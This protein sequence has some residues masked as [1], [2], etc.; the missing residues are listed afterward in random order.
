MIEPKHI[1]VFQIAMFVAIPSDVPI[2]GSQIAPPLIEFEQSL[3]LNQ[4]FGQH[5]GQ[6]SLLKVN[7]HRRTQLF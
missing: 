5:P 7:R 6:L 3:Y 1:S 2:Q 4:L